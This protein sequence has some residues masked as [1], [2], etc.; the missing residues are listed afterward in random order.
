[1]KLPK[2]QGNRALGKFGPK[3]GSNI[4][5]DVKRPVFQ[6]CSRLKGERTI[7]PPRLSFSFAD[8]Q[9]I[10]LLL[11]VFHKQLCY[12]DELQPYAGGHGAFPNAANTAKPST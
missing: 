2:Y 10:S 8:I 9:M 7:S 5:I 4:A 12:G 1:V 6:R 3:W 11:T